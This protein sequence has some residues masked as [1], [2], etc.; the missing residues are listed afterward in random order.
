DDV[1]EPATASIGTTI[2]GGGVRAVSQASGGA[3][4][5][6][7]GINVVPDW[8][9]AT[10]DCRHPRP[11]DGDQSTI[12]RRIAAAMHAYAL[13]ETG[14]PDDAIDIDLLGGGP[15]CAILDRF[16][17]GER[18]PLVGAI[19]RHGEAVS[20]F[21]PWIETAPGGTDATVMINDGNIRTLVEFG[22]A[23][24]FAHE[25]HEFVERDQ[26]AIGA[27][28]LAR[29]IVDILGVGPA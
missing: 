13:A 10:I 2:A 4:V 16:A 11:A 26:I 8:C 22:P 18:D 3:V 23:G 1:L 17:D 20:G 15:P 6:R 27:E 21:R 7:A 28:I 5:D 14:L 12:Q 25:P 9:E 19:L 24:A 29:T